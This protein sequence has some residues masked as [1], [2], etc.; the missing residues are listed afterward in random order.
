MSLTQVGRSIVSSRLPRVSTSPCGHVTFQEQR[1]E[2]TR[3]HTRQPRVCPLPCRMTR[4]GSLS[5][6]YCAS[7]IYCLTR[8]VRRILIRTTGVWNK[9]GPVVKPETCPNDFHLLLFFCNAWE[10]DQRA[11]LCSSLLRCVVDLSFSTV[12]EALAS[13]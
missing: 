3:K 10:L 1:R 9:R 4:R 5:A 6:K 12:K 7:L 8:L 11:L 13:L 2:K